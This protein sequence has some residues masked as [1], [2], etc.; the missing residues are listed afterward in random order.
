MEGICDLPLHDG[1]VPPHLM[2]RMRRLGSAIAR[3]IIEEFGPRELV[4]RLA[5]PLWMQAFSNV[6]GMDWDSSGATTVV[7]YVLKSFAPPTA[8]KD[9]GFAV[10]GGKGRDARRAPQELAAIDRLGIVDTKTLERVSR[11]SARIDSALLQD[12]YE[13]YI[14]SVFISSDG[15]WTVVQQGMNLEHYTARRY[16]IHGLRTTPSL[17]RDPHSGVACNRI[18]VALNVV[19]AEASRCREAL[20]RIVNELRPREV[21][22]LVAEARAVISGTRPLIGGFD[23]RVREL[24]NDPLVRYYTPRIDVDKVRRFLERLEGTVR[25]F[26]DLALAPGLG[27]ETVRALALVAHIIYGARPSHRDPVT[28]VLDPFIYSYAHGGKDGVPYPV[29]L[30]LLDTS[31]RVLEEALDR[32]RIDFEEKRRALR[33]LARFV[34]A[35]ARSIYSE[36]R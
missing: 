24:R 7:I 15:S 25:S 17:D 28:H 18:G 29:R 11:L 4:A 33:R 9:M 12:G 30:D 2:A 32:A 20:V 21:A 8:L 10:L 14:H 31:I 27:P 23:E 19:D 1:R 13:L 26:E 16:H 35:V 36:S 22:K 5:D 34:D 3:I 6:I